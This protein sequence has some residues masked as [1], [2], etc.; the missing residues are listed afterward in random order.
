MEGGERLLIDKLKP[1]ND[2]EI[3]VLCRKRLGI[4]QNELA[5]ELGVTPSHLSNIENGKYELSYKMRKQLC[6]LLEEFN[7]SREQGGA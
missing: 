2:S 3:L 4:K 7:L 5:K 1:E 6:R